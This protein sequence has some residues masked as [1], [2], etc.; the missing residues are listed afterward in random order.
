M[1]GGGELYCTVQQVCTV[2][3]VFEARSDL[4]TKYYM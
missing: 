1:E 2:Q 4:G 3:R